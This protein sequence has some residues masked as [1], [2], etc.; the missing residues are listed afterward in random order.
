M[1]Q[2]F[3]V[4]LALVVGAF[5]WLGAA[6]AQK[7]V[8]LVIGNSAYAHTPMLANPRNDAADV[9]AALTGLK[10]LKAYIESA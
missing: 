7:R 6:N 1:R 8:A 2:T 3:C 4:V 5:G 10:Q 9:A